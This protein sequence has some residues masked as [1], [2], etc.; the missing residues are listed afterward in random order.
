MDDSL[1]TN[2]IFSAAVIQVL[3]LLYITIHHLVFH[4]LASIPGPKLAA[5]TSWYECYYDVVKRGQYVFKIKELHKQYGMIQKH[6]LGLIYCS[7]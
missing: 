2:L 5:L 1:F 6:L 7:L 4:P 3:Y